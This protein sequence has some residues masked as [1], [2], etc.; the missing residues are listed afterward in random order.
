MKLVLVTTAM[1]MLLASIDAQCDTEQTACDADETCS[2]IME[3]VN[4]CE[5]E[6]SNCN[7]DVGALIVAAACANTEGAALVNCHAEADDTGED[8]TC[9]EV[10]TALAS[11]TCGTEFA[12][13]AAAVND[14]TISLFTLL[15]EPDGALTETESATEIGVICADTNGAALVTC[16]D[17]DDFVCPETAPAPAPAPI[18]EPSTT[19]G[20]TTQTMAL[21]AAITSSFALFL[22]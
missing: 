19:S 14:A 6:A 12:A 17:D 7:D 16:L 5:Q 15:A 18:N 21:F 9:T 8:P 11:E 10:D 20:A 13:V 4:Y 3:G 2:H 1:L 22:N